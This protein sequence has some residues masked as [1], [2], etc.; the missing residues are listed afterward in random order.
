MCWVTMDTTEGIFDVLLACASRHR[1]AM[2]PA[3][4]LLYW[5]LVL[6]VRADVTTRPIAPGIT[7][8]EEIARG[9]PPL[10]IHALRVD[11]SYPGVRVRCGQA[12]DAIT[13]NGP[14]KGREQVHAIAQRNN[15]LAAVN[16]DFF[17]YTG[18][19]LG[20]AIRDG[21]LLSEPMEF[22]ACA[23]FSPQGVMLDI[24]VPVGNILT[25]DGTML[26]LNGI[27]RVPQNGEIVALTP[28][29]GATPA[30]PKN[31]V[32]V[33]L[34][35]VN[36]PVKVS[37][38]QRGTVEIMNPLNPGE[39]L[40]TCPVGSVLLVGVGAAGD[41]LT[42]HCSRGDNVQFRF[43]LTSNGL[44]PTR[45]RYPSRA[46]SLRR[47]TFKPLWTNVEQ[48]VGGGPW[49]VRDG[50]VAIDSEA[51]GFPKGEFVDQRHPRTALGVMQDGKLL[52]I[53][54]DGRQ[55]SSSGV[56]L[57]ELAGIMKRYGAVNAINLDGGGSTTM[58]VGGGVINTPS[59]GRERPVADALLIYGAT[60]EI[61]G[62]E[63]YQIRPYSPDGVVV[64]SGQP[65][66]FTVT[67]ADG[68]PLH[69]DKAV[70]W[71]TADGLGHITQKGIFLGT[72]AGK[73]A[74]V[75]T[76]GTRVLTV[77]IVI[78]GG[79]AT[80]IK[81]VLGAVAN[82][83]PDRNL[84]T[85]TLLDRY[86]NP[87]PNQKI[88]VAVPGGEALSTLVTDAK[89]VAA[90]EIVWNTEPGKRVLTLTAGNAPPVTIHR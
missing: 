90:C 50:Q 84:L 36:L 43:D 56:S 42:A 86:G 16:A 48:A 80:Q 31:C 34:R 55:E 62:A 12:Q 83:P 4:C 76:I 33:V 35:D 69:D 88:V 71:G 24:L 18:D 8:T 41:S 25:A 78:S 89:G 38:D 85:V 29:Y 17:P 47:T 20:L 22:R 79:V 11:L 77:P 74:V 10:V 63:S 67:D 61:P 32:V 46:G 73:G 27:N 59:D 7:L 21:E 57:T 49:L 58:V 15:A 28:S 39:P 53:T 5:S 37:Q 19:P 68:K 87:V 54:V 51:E 81:A 26:P 2:L 14:T 9:N 60:Q 44:P 3:L 66:Q 64:P 65:I 70:F 1:I 13:L 45:G 30:L 6:P 52:L 23:G 82:N 72:H 40:P 75:A